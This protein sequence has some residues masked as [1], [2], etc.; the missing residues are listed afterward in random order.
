MIRAIAFIILT[1]MALC[2]QGA[3]AMKIDDYLTYVRQTL[4]Q[5]WRTTQDIRNPKIKPIILSFHISADGTMSRL[6]MVASSNSAST[7][8]LAIKAAKQSVQFRPLP[9][10]IEDLY[11]HAEYSPTD[12]KVT[13]HRIIS[14]GNLRG[15]T[16]AEVL[17]IWGLPDSEKNDVNG[18]TLTYGLSSIVLRDGKVL[19]YEDC[20]ELQIPLK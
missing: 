4:E 15:K 3:H 16:E 20:G 8:I 1:S 10:K 19:G 18:R 5:N 11:I 6:G 13:I 17:S 7:D 2:P 14:K 12:K 9:E